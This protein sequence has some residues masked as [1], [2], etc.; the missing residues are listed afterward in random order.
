MEAREKKPHHYNSR[1]VEHKA[2][3]LLHILIYLHLIMLKV[4][5]D[6]RMPD[7]ISSLVLTV[8]SQQE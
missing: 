8:Q 6:T 4:L 2:K 7:T 3:I 1:I 5:V